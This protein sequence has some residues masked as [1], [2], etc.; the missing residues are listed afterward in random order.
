MVQGWPVAHAAEAAGVSRQ[1]AYRWLKR[2]R[3]EGEAGLQD[4]SRRPHRDS[5]R[6]SSE[7]EERIVSDRIREKE[8]PH[9]VAAR[10]GVPRSTIL[11]GALP[12]GTVPP[13]RPGPHHRFPIRYER[14]CPGELV[15]VDIK[16]WG[17]YLMGAD[18]RSCDGDHR[19]SP[20]SITGIPHPGLVVLG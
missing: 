12:S 9:L 17:K 11:S 6:V 4:R 2:F 7:T 14:D 19:N 18:G 3:E 8:G 1:T 20:E 10:L 16:R 15:H 5:N 13:V